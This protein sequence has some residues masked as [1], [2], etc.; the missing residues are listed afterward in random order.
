MNFKKKRFPSR[1]FH[2][3]IWKKPLCLKSSYVAY[4]SRLETSSNIPLFFFVV[5]P[6][7]LDKSLGGL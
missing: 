4:L 5:V 7:K 2:L 3:K 6:F 1:P